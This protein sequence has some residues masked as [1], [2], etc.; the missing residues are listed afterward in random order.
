ML[1]EYL[2]LGSEFPCQVF[3]YLPRT[4]V[5]LHKFRGLYLELS[6]M[7]ARATRWRF[8]NIQEVSAQE[9]RPIRP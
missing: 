7:V 6:R 3:L 9:G 8:K 1:L 2:F 4:I 5:L